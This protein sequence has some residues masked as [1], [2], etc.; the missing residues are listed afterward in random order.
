MTVLVTGA[1]GFIGM[2]VS[3]A[4]LSS[5]RNVLGVDSLNSYYDP[6]LK[7]A[8]LAELSRYRS[9]AFA[10]ADIALEG[11]IGAAASGR[12]ITAIVHLAAQPGVRYSIE[13]PAAYIEANLVGH[14]RVL[15]FA[16]HLPDLSH[17]VYASSSS[18]YGAGTN[19]PFSTTQRTDRP[20]SLYAATKASCELMA[21]TYAHLYRIPATGLRFFTVYGPWGRPD[22]AVY[23]FTKAIFGGQP[24]RL[25]NGGAMKRDFTYIDDIVAGVTNC[26]ERPPVSDGEGAPHRVYN[27]GNHRSEPLMRLVQVLEK[28]IGRQALTEPAAMQPGEVVETFADIADARRDLGF[29]PTTSID[30]GIPKFVEWYR[31]YH[32]ID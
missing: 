15:E 28:A 19:L 2:H 31:R 25:F 11:A 9:F 26:L 13:H 32:K 6:A 16:R 7:R 5:G 22:M 20:V 1:A 30:I 8:R 14:F 21:Y 29:E 3:A 12:R 10:P 4:L 23:G 17:L 24:I 18:V 27:L